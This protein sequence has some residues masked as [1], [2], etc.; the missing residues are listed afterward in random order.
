MSNYEL[1]QSPDGN[2]NKPRWND[3]NKSTP[4]FNK[5]L[6]LF[7]WKVCSLIFF[8]FGVN[9]Y[10]SFADDMV[11]EQVMWEFLMSIVGKWKSWQIDDSPQHFFWVL[12]GM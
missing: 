5:T 6:F 4:Q 11:I 2:F 1:G 8:F 9:I 3:K 7:N 10:P 12:Y